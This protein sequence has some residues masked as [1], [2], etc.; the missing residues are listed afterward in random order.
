MKSIF[1][2]FGFGADSKRQTELDVVCGM[3]FVATETAKTSTH[4]GKTYYFCSPFCQESFD[5]DPRKYVESEKA[6][7]K[8]GSCH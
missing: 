5:A 7:K 2:K 8:G 6:D 3:K 4:N 1:S